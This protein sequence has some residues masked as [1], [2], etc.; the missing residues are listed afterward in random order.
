MIDA[1]KET[2]ALLLVLAMVLE[3]HPLRFELQIWFSS[4]PL[5]P[6]QTHR[7]SSLEIQT[8]NF[9]VGYPAV[10][11]KPDIQMRTVLTWDFFNAFIFLMKKNQ[12]V[13]LQELC[14]HKLEKYSK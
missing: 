6:S 3:L 14:I 2:K 8:G 4:L 5:A 10:T 11:Q 9:A 13:G 12:P 1:Q 7:A